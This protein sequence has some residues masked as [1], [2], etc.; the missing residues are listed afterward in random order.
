M[1][2]RARPYVRIPTP[3]V[4]VQFYASDEEWATDF[5]PAL[6][7]EGFEVLYGHV[8]A[9]DS[10]IGYIIFP[11]GREVWGSDTFEEQSVEVAFNGWTPAEG[12]EDEEWHPFAVWNEKH[13]SWIG[14]HVGDMLRLDQAPQDVY[15]IDRATFEATYK[16][17]K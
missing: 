10:R 9:E 6:E 2:A 5:L 17:E 14:F 11:Q 15:P 13:R 1:R 3:I 12:H 16:E 7:I 4:A 8:G